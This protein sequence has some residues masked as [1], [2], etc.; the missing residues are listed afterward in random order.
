MKATDEVSATAFNAAVRVHDGTGI[1]VQTWLIPRNADHETVRAWIEQR[2]CLTQ[3]RKARI[4]LP[5]C[6]IEV[7]PVDRDRWCDAIYDLGA[8]VP[9]VC[10]AIEP[11]SDHIVIAAGRRLAA[12]HIAPAKR[13]FE[14]Q[15]DYPFSAVVFVP[16]SGGF[17]GVHELGATRY[18]LGG[19][20]EWQYLHDEPIARTRLQA[21]QLT[22]EDLDGH[23][24][25]IDIRDGK[26]LR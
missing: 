21:G 13:L 14:T 25:S 18:S 3:K 16:G 26:L 9:Y 19:S 2:H 6:L 17:I 8:D 11:T 22:I 7:Q 23:S 20:E 12:Y 4:S 24:A 5:A 10:W 15:A 1:D